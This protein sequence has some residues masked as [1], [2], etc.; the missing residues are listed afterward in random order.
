[1]ELGA[2]QTSLLFDAMQRANVIEA[3]IKT[4]EHDP[5]WADLVR[6]RVAHEV[7]TVPLRRYEEN[8]LAYDG[9]DLTNVDL[10]PNIDL[11][12]IDGP[13][14]ASRERR[15]ARHGCLQLLDRLNPT[16]F[17]IIIDDAERVGEAL[18]CER[19]ANRLQSEGI[20]YARGQITA[21]KRQTVFASGRCSQTAY[22]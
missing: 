17:V 1:L 15:Y 12:V 20:S 19:I 13:P 4:I 2:G 6:G 18:L 14:A 3:K 9:Y 10:N 8:G 11:L 7:E 22:Y 21:N 5:V 16:G